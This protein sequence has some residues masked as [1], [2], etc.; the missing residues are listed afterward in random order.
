MNGLK[1]SLPQ[2]NSR[3]LNVLYAQFSLIMQFDSVYCSVIVL[4]FIIDDIDMNSVEAWKTVQFIAKNHGSNFNIALLTF[5]TV[6]ISIS[7]K[8]LQKVSF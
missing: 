1:E 7:R 5:Y 8:V 3:L 6:A 2:M 4:L